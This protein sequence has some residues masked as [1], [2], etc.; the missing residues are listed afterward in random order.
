MR[1]TRLMAGR[2]LALCLAFVLGFS[3]AFG[4]IAGGI[5]FA[6]AGL[7]IDR[8]NQ[9]GEMFGINIPVDQF[10]DQEAEK[11]ATSLT[12]QDLIFEIQELTTS[13]LT[14]EQLIERYGLL[15]PPDVI[16][17]VPETVLNE[18]P[19][20]TLFTPAG[21][22]AVMDTVTVADVMSMIPEDLAGTIISN[23]LRDAMSNRTLS[24]IVDMNLG[25]IF[26]GVELGYLVGVNYVPDENGE[27]QPVWADPANPTLLE[28]IAPL[29]LGGILSAATSSGDVLEVIKNSIGDV[30]LQSILNTFL[31][32]VAMINNL[33]GEVTFG[34]LIVFDESSGKHTIDIMVALEGKKVGSF[35]GYI[36]TEN[37]DPETEEVSHIWTDAEGKKIVGI[38][39]KVA[40][41]CLTDFMNGTVSFDTLLDD[42]IIADVLG[43]EK[44]KNL[45]V[46]M[47]DNLENPLVVDE[48]I[49]VWYAGD[50]P[51]D[52]IMNTFAD[53]TLDWISTSVS[54]LK[55]A[56]ILG[57]YCYEGKWYVWNIQKVG[58]ADAIVLTPGTPVM[59]EIA[60]T[61]ID[62]L[63]GIESTLKDV[64]I[65]TLLGYES[66]CN[67][68]GEHLYWSMGVDE[69]GEHNKPTGI[70]ASMADLTING[71]SN[72]DLQKTIDNICLA[73]VLG[74][75]YGEDGKWYKGEE[76]V[77]GPMAALA[78]SKIGTISEDI[79]GISIGEMLGHTPVYD[80][81]ENGEFVLDEDG[82]KVILHWK[83]AT[84]AE[85]T[86]IMGAFVDLSINDMKDSNKIQDS[87]QH[88]KVADVMG[89]YEE[90]G[91]W[92]NSDGTKATGVMAAIAGTEVGGISNAMQT[93]TIG[94]LLDLHKDENGVWYN[95]D[96]TKASGVIAA[97]ADSTVGT[98]SSEINDVKV[99]ELLNYVHLDAENENATAGEG[100]YTYDE[101]TGTYTKATGV[102]AALADSTINNMN[103]NLQNLMIGDVAGYTY[104][105]DGKWYTSEGKEATGVLAE[106]ADLTVNDLT[107]D[108]AI[109]DKIGNVKLGDALGYTP[110]YATDANGNYILDTNGNKVVDHWED[111]N[112]EVT[113]IMSAL[114]NNPINDMGSAI[115]DLTL[116]QVL[117]GD[118][119]GL[120]SII[121]GDTPISGIN[122]AINNSIM[123]TPLQFF[124][125]QGLIAFEGNTMNTLDFLC[126]KKEENLPDD[127]KGKYIVWID[128]IDETKDSYKDKY[129]RDFKFKVEIM[130]V[131]TEISCPNRIPSWRTQPLQNSLGYIVDLMAP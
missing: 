78:G 116:D 124:I 49:V 99:G 52:K 74:Y 125:D 68:N 103:A 10:V 5:Y 8:V 121:P 42:L 58:G 56:D 45:P 98:L 110:V 47:H 83:D 26:D 95:S 111:E 60:G 4:A 17:K 19:F 117:P 96:G 51:A 89:L 76:V 85:V 24:D 107:K 63:S 87:I 16:D 105:E 101:V 70:T 114:V 119:T 7:S 66:V 112:G 37:V 57:Y 92:Y 80:V 35:L 9:W 67:E 48:E 106:L 31:K 109:T 46:F 6:F 29:D 93:I 131:E 43:Y 18:V 44:G 128:D 62:G 81:D 61:S 20:T 22:E 21:V 32:D 14:L 53:K 55:L 72:G 25:Y 15:L 108:G 1:K 102:T 59:S 94:E 39:A 100:W 11:P 91:V 84:G 77:T 28:L 88:I 13:A 34:D 123:T 130:G 41:I 38:T 86:G 30:A 122:G 3:S 33:L 75:T 97:L 113:G 79:N 82:N 40:D 12:L 71:L 2:V 64:Q 65:G 54:T 129:D 27:Y 50:I 115:D 126:F 90:D 118:K 36:E 73:D 120:L 69:N 127:Q 23:P 104:G